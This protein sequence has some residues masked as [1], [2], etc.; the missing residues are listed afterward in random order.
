MR[1]KKRVSDKLKK[2]FAELGDLPKELITSDSR[3]VL[4]GNSEFTV[5]NYSGIVEYEVNRIRL[6]CDSG[7]V[8]VNGEDLVINELDNDVL[9]IKG[10][11]RGLEI[12]EIKKD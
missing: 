12:E 6:R 4:L 10:K 11:I 9:F 5:E 8:G 1:K 3:M 7:I 2:R